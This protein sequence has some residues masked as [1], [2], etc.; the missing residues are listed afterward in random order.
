MRAIG[1]HP[2]KKQLSQLPLYIVGQRSA[3][4]AIELGFHDIKFIARRADQLASHITTVAH[5]D[6]GQFLYLTGTSLAFDMKPYLTKHNLLIERSILYQAVAINE[7]N[8]SARKNLA[9]GQ[10]NA[11]ILLSP[12]TARIY[13]TLIHKH[14]LTPH[15]HPIT[16]LC[17]SQKVAN[18]LNN[19]TPV[20]I[21][22]PDQPDL[23]ALLSMINNNT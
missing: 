16:H 20:P 6:T 12:R 23:S 21:Q 22:F 7:M 17:L 2:Q 13:T 18:E 5:P 15:L 11:V 10:I 8:L 19:L 4:L 1:K 14:Q 9:N 3:D